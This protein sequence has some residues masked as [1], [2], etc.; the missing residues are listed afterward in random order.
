MII[1]DMMPG[2][3]NACGRYHDYQINSKSIDVYST[4]YPIEGNFAIQKLIN[5]LETVVFVLK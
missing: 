2:Q 1:A 3:K 5:N 4:K